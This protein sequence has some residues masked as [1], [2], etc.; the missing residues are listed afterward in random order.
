MSALDLVVHLER[1]RDGCQRVVQVC[2][3]IG[4]EGDAIAL[5]E[6]VRWEPTPAG[7]G[8]H[9][10]QWQLQP[11]QPSFQARLADSGLERAWAG[12]F[13]AEACT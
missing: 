2:D 9:G 4:I 13:V 1:H 5:N 6:I 12:L 3:G 10:R 7:E 8:G 11:V